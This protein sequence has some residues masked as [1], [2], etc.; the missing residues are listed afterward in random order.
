MIEIFINWL[1]NNK[2]EAIA[3][4]LG[5]IN[6]YF[7]IKEKAIFWILATVTAV[8]F[9]YIFFTSQLYAYMLLQVYYFSISI[10]GF[11]Y[12]TKGTPKNNKKIP[13]THITKNWIAASTGGFIVLYIFLSF[14]LKKYTNSP[15][16]FIDAFVTTASLFGAFFMMKKFIE[17]WFIWIFSDIIAIILLFYKELYATTFLQT[18]YFIFAIIGYFEW[19]KSMQ[20]QNEQ[21]ENK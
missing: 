9:F 11:Y 14:I 13:I 12:W 18:F 3:S 2:I 19:K 20:K 16:P 8:M 17:S 15:V 1:I 4:I 7:G 6:I 21:P 10:Y 5:L